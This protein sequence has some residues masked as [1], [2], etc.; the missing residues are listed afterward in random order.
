LVEDVGSGWLAWRNSITAYACPHVSN[1]SL[2]PWESESQAGISTVREA[3]GDSSFWQNLS[4]HF[5]SETHSEVVS[6]DNV[7]TIKSIGML[8]YM[9]ER[10]LGP[11][12]FQSS[13]QLLEDE[14]FTLL[15]T[16]IEELIQDPD[17]NK[18][19]G[20]AEFL[21]GLLNGKTVFILVTRISRKTGAK[22]WPMH[23]Q[24][25][26]W[27]WAMPLLKTTFGSRIKTDTL[28]VWMSF[29]EVGLP[30]CA[31]LLV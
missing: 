25:R 10:L 16:L 30:D 12:N 29:L 7:A 23:G 24:K 4:T 21:A 28:P 14:S 13:V 31:F 17:Q 18:Q 6:S 2:T 19:R 11:P 27:D 1:P 22:H 15:Q 26:L 5:S 20:A 9:M 8:T 3:A